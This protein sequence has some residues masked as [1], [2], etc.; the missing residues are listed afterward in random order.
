MKIPISRYTSS[1]WMK[2][3]S[4]KLWSAHWLLTVHRSQLQFVGDIEVLSLMGQEILIVLTQ[5][6]VKIYKNA[7]PHRGMQLISE[8]KS[9]QKKIVSQLHNWQF[10]LT[11]ESLHI[12]DPVPP[13][14]VALTE[15]GCEERMGFV[16]VN[17]AE[18]PVS[19]DEYLKEAVPWTKNYG[20]QFLRCHE[21]LH[22][23]V[24]ANWKTACDLQNEV[25]HLQSLHPNI[26]GLVN[27]T[28][29]KFSLGKHHA[30][31][32]I[33]MFERS[34]RRL[35]ET[36]LKRAK[37]F[38][39]SMGISENVNKATVALNLAMTEKRPLTLPEMTDIH[40]VYLFPNIQL[41]MRQNEILVFRYLPDPEDPNRCTFTK[42]KLYVQPLKNPFVE[43]FVSVK[44]R[45]LGR[46]VS[47]DLQAV[48]KQQRGLLGNRRGH[49]NLIKQDIVIAHTHKQLNALG[50]LDEE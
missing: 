32:Q 8:R 30:L 49:M 38:Y 47:I 18:E 2:Q 22:C 16:W 12:P 41:K 9:K 23:P 24:L 5:I 29:A 37:K 36:A 48:E 25:Y 20:L 27:D 40:M 17:F 34:E 13:D 19:I 1:D 39:Q 15:L 7:C 46:N 28:E 21:V 6:G 10:A 45:K 4:K 44:D 31:V 11:G 33:P 3:E 43:H 50:L 14:P 35:T 26:L 42:F